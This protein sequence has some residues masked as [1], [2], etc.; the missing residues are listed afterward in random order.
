[1]SI[2]TISIDATIEKFLDNQIKNKKAESKSQLVRDAIHFFRE[3]L[4]LR[5]LMLGSKEVREGKLLK[6]DLRKL[7]ARL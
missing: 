6:G 3:E 2:L 4:E 7:A 5:D 1:M